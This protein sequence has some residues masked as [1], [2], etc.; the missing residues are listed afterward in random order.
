MI[1]IDPKEWGKAENYKFLTSA[2]IP[3]P[4]AYVTSV[5]KEG[6]LN[7]APFS[8]FNVVS[9]EPPILMVS[10]GRKNGVQKDTARNILEQGEFVVHMV[11]E[12]NVKK[13][14]RSAMALPPEESEV[15][16][17]KLNPEP[18][19]FVSVPSLKDAPVRIECVLEK[20]LVFEEGESATDVI[21]G[22]IVQY[23]LD[24]KVA[25]KGE[26]ETG[27]VVKPKKAKVI[28]RL[29]GNRYIKQGKI[30]S[31]KRPVYKPKK[32]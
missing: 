27:I 16:R 5:S 32:R 10:I 17:F 2:V 24:E 30:F 9:A 18:S 25:G 8:Y 13:V 22:R 7:A 4:I 12:S 6:V 3:R 15:T 21:F 23:V 14:N 28:G 31:L 29:G 11:T 20:H 26:S 1:H 19:R